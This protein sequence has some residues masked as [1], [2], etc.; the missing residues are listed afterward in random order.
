[1]T[2]IIGIPD[3][4][5]NFSDERKKDYVKI[6]NAHIA[7]GDGLTSEFWNFMYEHDKTLCA[8]MK[9]KRL[10][11]MDYFQSLTEGQQADYMA[12]FDDE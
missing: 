6:G 2:E 11:E 1:M 4:Y 3:D 7:R 8:R 5:E 9:K 10:A 12:G